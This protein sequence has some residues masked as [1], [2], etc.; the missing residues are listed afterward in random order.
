MTSPTATV[1][2]RLVLSEPEL[3][4]AV[5][6][7]ILAEAA[8]WAAVEAGLAATQDGGPSPALGR[9]HW[10]AAFLIKRRP[11]LG[12]KELGALTGLSKQGASRVLRDLE[13][14]GFVQKGLGEDAR[15]RPAALTPAGR[16][17]E[18]AGATR[19]RAALARAYRAA[20]VEHAAGA[21]RVWS[22]LAGSVRSPRAP[23]EG[24]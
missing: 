10:R 11:G 5:E 24:A 9:G 21:R 1:D 8:A 2:P 14:A 22:A 16:A 23:E 6:Q 15:R 12:V 7:L 18:A 19:L 3:D 4:A 13:T 20:G 17:F